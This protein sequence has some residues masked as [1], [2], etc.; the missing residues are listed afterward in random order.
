MINLLLHKHHQSVTYFVL[1]VVAVVEIVQVVVHFEIPDVV[2]QNVAAV[3]GQKTVDQEANQTVV[4]VHF[5]VVAVSVFS[6]LE[7]TQK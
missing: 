5:G 6:S 1:T 4:L 7:A 3:A 2:R